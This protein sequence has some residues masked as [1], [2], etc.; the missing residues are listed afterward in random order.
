MFNKKIT[1]LFV[2]I[3][4]V[5]GVL[6]GCK[7]QDQYEKYTD[8]FFDTFD[9]VVTVMGYTKSKD[10][11]DAYVDKIEAEFV[12]LNKL[13]DIYNNYEGINNIKTINDNA[14]VKPVKV[15]KEIIDLILFAK[16]WYEATGG[17]TN[18]AMGAVLKIWHDYRTDG[19]DNPE[20]AKL[21]P[22]EALQE[23]AKHT[24]ISKVIVDVE[25]STVY[26]EDEK[27][28]LD[29]GSVAKGYA[30]ELV[31]QM[32]VKEGFTS[33]II[34]AGGN[35]R[36]FGKPLDGKRDFWGI[37]VQNPDEFIV[38]DGSSS[39]DTLFVND[40]SVVTSGDYQRYYVVDGKAYHHLIDPVTLMPG[41]YFRAV[42][43]VTD[44]SGLGDFLST[45]IFLTPYE[46]GRKL[47]ESLDGVEALWIKK[48]GTIEATKG[49]EKLMKSKGASANKRN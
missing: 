32:I 35:V 5:I 18:V 27:M 13:Y 49:M 41:D 1:A 48:D 8:S 17:K 15:D 40:K 25:N 29:V 7:A 38:S 11:F 21:P 9:T 10:E 6:T 2:A 3:F 16:K 39:L 22:M 26:L 30:T 4:L 23:A 24:D 46:E 28:S 42:A 14:G 45:T 37:A 47:V 31:T 19:K 43:I 12:R 20:I 33:G 44:D 34:N 36:T